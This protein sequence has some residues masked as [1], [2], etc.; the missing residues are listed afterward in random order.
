MAGKDDNMVSLHKRYKSTERLPNLSAFDEER[1]VWVKNLEDDIAD[2][3][4]RRNRLLIRQ[5]AAEIALEEI[6]STS[7]GSSS[8]ASTESASSTRSVIEVEHK[9]QNGR[10]SLGQKVEPV[11]PATRTQRKQWNKRS[12]ADFPR[13]LRHF[14]VS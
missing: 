4:E 7:S 11:E 9:T 2:E 8:A 14:Q 10:E 12:Q 3:D 6:V 5:A 1:I 13:K